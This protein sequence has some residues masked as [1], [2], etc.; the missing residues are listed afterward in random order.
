M[1]KVLV[2]MGLKLRAKE[3]KEGHDIRPWGNLYIFSMFIQGVWKFKT[4]YS[5]TMRLLA[6]HLT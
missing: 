6:E 4:T 3:T 5:T 2:V 1:W